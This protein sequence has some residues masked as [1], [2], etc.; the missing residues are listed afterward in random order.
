MSKNINNF[1]LIEIRLS[2]LE[3]GETGGLTLKT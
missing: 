1:N 2:P 3:K